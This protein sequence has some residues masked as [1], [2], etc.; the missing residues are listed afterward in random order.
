MG[1]VDRHED[2]GNLKLQ[3]YSGGVERVLNTAEITALTDLEQLVH[4]L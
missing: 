3:L 2:R 4:C 1:V